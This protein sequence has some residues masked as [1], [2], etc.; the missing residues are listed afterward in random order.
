MGNL[1]YLRPNPLGPMEE[2]LFPGFFDVAGEDRRM[3]ADADA[4]DKRG[5]T[6]PGLENPSAHRILAAA[7]RRVQ[8]LDCGL[9][10]SKDRRL[11]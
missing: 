2:R 4:Q 3:V 9:T 6:V 7:T 5:I 1:Q 11:G 10:P 8:G